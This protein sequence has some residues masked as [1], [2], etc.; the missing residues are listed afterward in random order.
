[1]T[2]VPRDVPLPPTKIP[3]V[4]KVSFCDNTTRLL[5]VDARVT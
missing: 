1:V 4:F 2:I 3:S 5:L